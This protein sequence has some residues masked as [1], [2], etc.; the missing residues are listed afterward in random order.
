[1]Q[2]LIQERVVA[3]VLSDEQ[4]PQPAWPLRVLD[5]ARWLRRLPA[6]VI[7]IGVRP[8]HVVPALLAEAQDR[9]AA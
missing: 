5:G 9:Q 8:E 1:M 2:R 6:R 7:G 3:Q 4:A